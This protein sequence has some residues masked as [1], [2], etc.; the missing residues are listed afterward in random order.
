M[1]LYPISKV[2]PDSRAELSETGP[3]QKHKDGP[4]LLLFCFFGVPFYF[5]GFGFGNCPFAGNT[6]GPVNTFD[7]FD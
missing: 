6:E 4:R 1:G 3:A 2:S 7:C 5:H